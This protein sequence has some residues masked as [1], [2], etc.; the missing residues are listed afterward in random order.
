MAV[1]LMNKELNLN[2]CILNKISDVRKIVKE[3]NCGLVPLDDYIDD[4]SYSFY[5]GDNLHY[6]AKGADLL[7]KIYEKSIKEYYG[8]K[9]TGSINV[10]HKEQLPEGVIGKITATADSDFWGKYANNVF[11]APSASFESPQYS[12][13]I[14]ITKKNNKND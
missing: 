3:Y 8:I 4:T 12:Y 2:S 6:N 5:L 13:R 10:E 11:L 1:F 7:S 14:E 9:Y